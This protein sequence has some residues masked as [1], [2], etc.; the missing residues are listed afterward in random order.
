MMD[1]LQYFYFFSVISS[2]VFCGLDKNFNRN[3]P[4][5][6]YEMFS[7]WKVHSNVATFLCFLPVCTL[8]NPHRICVYEQA[9]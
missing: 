2:S 8:K 3:C 1:L 7:N 5:I 4:N 6:D 9:V